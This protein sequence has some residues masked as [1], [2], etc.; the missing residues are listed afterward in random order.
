M[1]QGSEPKNKLVYLWPIEF[2]SV[3]GYQ[4]NSIEQELS[5]QQMVL[6]Q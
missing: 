5:F 4:D 3:Q 6:G 2:L 1:K